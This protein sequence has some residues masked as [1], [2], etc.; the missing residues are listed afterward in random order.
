MKKQQTNKTTN[1]T[2]SISPAITLSQNFHPTEEKFLSDTP[3]FCELNG[4][5]AR[6]RRG[7]YTMTSDFTLYHT[8]FLCFF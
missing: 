1:K 4:P 8:D 3:K 7:W 5:M 6:G 2:D